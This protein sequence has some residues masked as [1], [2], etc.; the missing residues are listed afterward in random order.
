MGKRCTYSVG[1]SE[2]YYN[3]INFVLR[4]GQEHRDFKISQLKFYS[5]ENPEKP[6]EKVE[7]IKYTEFGSKNRPGGR[8]QLNL[9]NKVILRYCVCPRVGERC[10]VHLLKDYLS[11]L[12]KCAYEQD[13]LYWKECSKQP[14]SK[15][16]AWYKACPLGHNTLDTKLK[17][18]LQLD[19]LKTENRSNHSLRA[20][21]ITRMQEEKVPENIIMEQSGHLL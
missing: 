4:G 9:T 6:T 8:C 16:D 12:P 13:I 10:H 17:T 5:V 20:T 19:G 15:A 1:S 14:I 18:I 11:K 2:C 7:V 3:G 21:A